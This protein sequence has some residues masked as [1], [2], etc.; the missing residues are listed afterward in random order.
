LIATYGALKWERIAKI[1]NQRQKSRGS[2]RTGKQLR[3]RY[4][5]Y[6]QT[7]FN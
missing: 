4:H 7:N 1:F 6:L 3:E 2:F 5:N